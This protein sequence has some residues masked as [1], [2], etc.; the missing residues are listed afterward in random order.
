MQ[1]RQAAPLSAELCSKTAGPPGGESQLKPH[2]VPTAGP[3]WDL[4]R[5]G[6]RNGIGT[7]VTYCDTVAWCA[8][9]DILKGAAWHQTRRV[10]SLLDEFLYD[11]FSGSDLILFC[12]SSGSK[13]AKSS[14]QVMAESWLWTKSLSSYRLLRDVFLFLL[15]FTLE[16]IS[17]ARGE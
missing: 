11:L 2:L 3:P 16:T 7:I 5:S 14:Q 15:F 9:S 12:C 6:P 10:P 13:S 4:K 1:T 8:Q 17:A